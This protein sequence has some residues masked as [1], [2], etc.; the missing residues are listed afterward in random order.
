MWQ[1]EVRVDLDAIR[2]NVARLCAATTAEVMAVV[3]ADGYGHGAVPSARAA[4][5]AGATRLGVCTLP[6]AFAL[7]NAG[8]T[9]PVL[10]WL[11]G[12]GQPRQEAI[13]ADIDLSA[14]SLEQLAEV[15]EGARHAG[16]PARV[17][18]KIDTG[19]HRAGATVND[20]PA[21]LEAAAKAQAE[22]EIEVAG[23][24]SHLVYAD[25]PGH[26]TTD[27]QLSVFRDALDAADAH[28]LTPELRHIANSAA[29]LTMPESHFD[30]VRPGLAI[31]GLSP[32]E[33]ETFGLRPAMSVRGQVVLT[34][35]VGPGEGVGYGHAYFTRAETTLA[36]IPIGYADGIPRALGNVGQLAINGRRYRI[37]GRVSMDQIVVDCGD[38]PV[39]VGDEAIL[40]GAGDEGE[41]TATDWADDLGTIN[42]E[43]VA[44]FTGPR[45]PH[46]L[47]G[48]RA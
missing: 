17:H 31:Y 14:S 35:R 43:V 47:Q 28:G 26:Q 5:D 25:A 16:R 34:K 1:A 11:V 38:D 32:I 45:L 48:E 8:I 18:L 3:K 33:G 44:R 46:V 2:A 27:D 39:R 9:V 10:A 19:L 6:E 29:T 23:V 4:L 24:W 21:L 40:F 13:L 7:R 42:Y 41:P 20:W 12:P 37:A 30:M 36:L 22:G 15:A